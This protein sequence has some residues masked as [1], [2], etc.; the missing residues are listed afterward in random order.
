[1]DMFCCGM[2]RSCSTWQYD[3]AQAILRSESFNNTGLEVEACG[4]LTGPEYAE[5]RRATRSRGVIRLFKGHEGHP[6]YTRAMFR[7]R[8]V[9]LYAHRD[10][11]DVLFSLMFKR[12]QTFQEILKTGMVH[13]ILVNDRFWRLHPQVMV[14]R[15]DD[16]MAERGVDLDGAENAQ[17][18]DQTTLLH[19]NHIRPESRSWRELATADER[20]V[21]QRML[22]NWLAENDYPADTFDDL[23]RPAG[24]PLKWRVDAAEGLLRCHSR[25]TSSKYHRVSAPIKQ[26]LGL[27]AGE[28]RSKPLARVDG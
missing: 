8:A 23:K 19:W 3:V 4:Y 28:K 6:S 16:I 13:Q 17:V 7:G 24:R 22:G 15:Y 9:G 27:G 18:Y 26:W 1:M 21:M 2:Y 25:E 10:V 11:R 20:R 12:R 5:F 14:Q